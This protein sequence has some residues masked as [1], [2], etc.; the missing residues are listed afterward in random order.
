MQNRIFIGRDNPAILVFS[1]TGDFADGGLS[2]F[3]DIQVAIDSETYSTVTDPTKVFTTDDNTLRIA[4]GDS[5]SLAAGYYHVD[6]V[7]FS[8]TY[9]DGYVLACG[10]YNGLARLQVIDC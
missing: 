4:I 7:G 5:T 9:N 2:N 10:G 3:D 6:V 8:S 1:F